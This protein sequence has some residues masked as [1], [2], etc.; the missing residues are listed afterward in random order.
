MERVFEV[1]DL[2]ERHAQI[3]QTETGDGASYP[4]GG[5]HTLQLI[6]S[7]FTRGVEQKIIVAPITQAEKALRN[8]GQER[9]HNANFQAKNDVKD[10]A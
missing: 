1:K 6:E 10:N 4:S 5:H 8:P 7:G 2:P 9:Q 3:Q